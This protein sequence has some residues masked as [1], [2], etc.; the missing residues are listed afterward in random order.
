MEQEPQPLDFGTPGFAGEEAIKALN[1][2]NCAPA[3]R[4]LAP[5]LEAQPPAPVAIAHL[6]PPAEML[7]DSMENLAIMFDL[8]AQVPSTLHSRPADYALKR[9][10]T[11]KYVPMW[12]FTREDLWEAAR[13]ICWSDENE[14]L[15]IMQAHKGNV[16][17]RAVNSLAASKNA[18][19]HHQL[20]YT[21]YMFTKN[22]FLVTIKNA[23]WGN[24]AVDT[25]NWFFH[26]LDNHPLWEE[27]LQGE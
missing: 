11:F 20:S 22:H 3:P 24:K 12:Y 6:D 4:D 9:L 1:Q 27:G 2:S 15:A 16:T 14:T 18:K 13:T 23:K 19:L 8:M 21:E 17:V 10:E 5:Q 25:F 26:N 7:E